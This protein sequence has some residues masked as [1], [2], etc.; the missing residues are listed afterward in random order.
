MS[1]VIAPALAADKKTVAF[2]E[3]VCGACHG[4]KGQGTPK[5][6]PPLAGNKF[7]LEASAEEIGNLITKGRQGDQKRYKDLASPMP[8]QSLSSDKLSAL[9]SYLKNELQK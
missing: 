7:V 3:E 2:F 5:L 4:E 8:A 9:I 1:V 6:A